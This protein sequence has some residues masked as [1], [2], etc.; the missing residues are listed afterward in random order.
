[1]DNDESVAGRA[2]IGLTTLVHSVSGAFYPINEPEENEVLMI[3]N[4]QP[5]RLDNWEADLRKIKTEFGTF[6]HEPNGPPELY[7]K[8]LVSFQIEDHNDEISQIMVDNPETRQIYS[9]LVNSF[10]YFESF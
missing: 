8:W 9:K 6:C 7:E 10:E 1:M 5:V 3:H 4:S 2:R